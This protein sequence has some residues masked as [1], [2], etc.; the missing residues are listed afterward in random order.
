M[1][2]CFVCASDGINAPAF[3]STGGWECIRDS[4]SEKIAGVEHGWVANQAR[5]PLWVGIIHTSA[6]AAAP[7]ILHAHKV[8]GCDLHT[9]TETRADNKELQRCVC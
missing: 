8:P 3:T 5:G 2:N 7:F 6:T 9:I 1:R 4:M